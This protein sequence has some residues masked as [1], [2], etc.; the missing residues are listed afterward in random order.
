MFGG[1]L[2]EPEHEVAVPHLLVERGRCKSA[3]V[4]DAH[5]IRRK[6]QV[7][8]QPLGVDLAVFAHLELDLESN[9]ISKVLIPH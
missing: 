7:R 8:I 5:L 3:Q 4:K 1:F 9:W 6:V 2:S